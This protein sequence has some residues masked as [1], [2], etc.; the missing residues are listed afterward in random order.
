MRSYVSHGRVTPL[1]VQINKH[2]RRNKTL[3]SRD[4]FVFNIKSHTKIA[5]FLV[6]EPVSGHDLL[7]VSVLEIFNGIINPIRGDSC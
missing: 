4:T 3:D 7:F 2:K 5:R 6:I 1:L